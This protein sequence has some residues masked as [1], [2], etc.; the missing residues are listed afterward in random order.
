M[1]FCELFVEAVVEGNGGVAGG[2][3][4]GGEG[5]VL[6]AGIGEGERGALHV[7]AL[8]GGEVGGVEDE[9]ILLGELGVLP[10]VV[11]GEGANPFVV[12]EHDGEAW[13]C[14]RRGRS[15]LSW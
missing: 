11:G 2:P 15:W 14:G 5:A 6:G 3:A 1:V 10:F 9:G 8:A 13:P 7:A 12:V 4:V